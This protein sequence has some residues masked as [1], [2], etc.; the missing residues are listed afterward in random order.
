MFPD[1]HRKDSESLVNFFKAKTDVGESGVKKIVA[2]FKAL[3]QIGDFENVDDMEY[4]EEEPKQL[5]KARKE[6]GR[7][8][9]SAPGMAV[10]LN[11]QLTLPSDASGEAYDKFFAAMKKHL[12]NE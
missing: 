6:T 8:S 1:A 9:A 3:A 10:N 5:P 7:L 12:L 11:I 2:T 4:L